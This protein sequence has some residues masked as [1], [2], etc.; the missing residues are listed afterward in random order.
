[1]FATDIFVTL[2]LKPFKSFVLEEAKPKS[3]KTFSFGAS[4][5]GT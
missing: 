1:M 4:I 3:V 2:N 5:A